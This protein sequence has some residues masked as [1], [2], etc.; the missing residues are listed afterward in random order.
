VRPVLLLLLV[1]VLLLVPLSPL[2]LSK[3]AMG[4]RP[5]PKGAVSAIATVCQARLL[6]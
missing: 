5:R 6:Y 4:S 1:L 3:G 2:M